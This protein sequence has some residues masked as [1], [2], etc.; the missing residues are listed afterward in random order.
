[1]LPALSWAEF[2]NNKPVISMDSANNIQESGLYKYVAKKD[3]RAAFRAEN[4]CKINTYGNKSYVAKLL[5]LFK[6]SNS[7]R[8]KEF[9]L[10]V[11]E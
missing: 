5:D 1:M 4:E 6:T 10:G 11:Q 2:T 8:T 9:W 3:T 7:T